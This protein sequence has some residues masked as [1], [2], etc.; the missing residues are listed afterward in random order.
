MHQSKHN[1]RD[2]IGVREITIKM[3]VAMAQGPKGKVVTKITTAR[4]NQHQVRRGNDQNQIQCCNCQGWGHMWHECSSTQNARPLNSRR[5]S[6]NRTSPST[7]TECWTCASTST[8]PQPVGVV[9]SPQYLGLDAT[10]ELIGRVNEADIFVGDIWVTALINTRAQVSTI[11]QDVC[12]NHRYD[13]HPM[14][15]ILYLE[16]QGGS[17]FC[18]RGLTKLLLKSLWSKIM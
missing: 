10:I 1:D 17:P 16:E 15:Q 6:N 8:K 18:T 2:P 3:P 12:D 7:Q 4:N 5:G 13:I 9:T 11:T 14:K